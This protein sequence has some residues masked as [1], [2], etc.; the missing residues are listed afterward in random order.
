[1][2]FIDEVHRLNRAVE[3]VLYP[4]MEDFALDLIVGKGPSARNVRLKLPRF[5]GDWRNN[6]PRPPHV[7]I[8]GSVWGGAPA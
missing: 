3:E 4:G 6:S 2:L 1:M 8:A 7:A 5:Y